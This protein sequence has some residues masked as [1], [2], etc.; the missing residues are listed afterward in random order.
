M[1]FRYALHSL[2]K[3]PGF[4]AIAVLALGVGLGLSTTMFAILDSIRHP[5]SVYRDVQSLYVVSAWTNSRTS[6]FPLAELY[7]IVREQTRSF[8]AVT[9]VAGRQMTLRTPDGDEAVPVYLTTPGYFEVTGLEVERG[10][11]FAPGETEA[12]LISAILWRRLFGER[13]DFHDAFITLDSA[14]YPVVGVVPADDRMRSVWLPKPGAGAATENQWFGLPLVRLKPGVTVEQ[15]D[16]ELKLLGKTVSQ[17]LNAGREA[18][19]FNIFPLVWQ[20]DEIKDVHKAMLGASLGVLLIA[21]VNLAH[22]MLARGMARRRELALRMALGA[23]RSVVIRQMLAECGI[24]TL[25]GIAIGVVIAVWGGAVLANRMPPEVE[26]I[27]MVRPHLSW[28]VFASGAAAATVSALLFGLLPAV[29]IAASVDIADPLKDDSGTT[30]GRVRQRYNGLVIAEVAL[31]LVLLMGAGLLLRT[32]RQL[33]RY[34]LGIDTRTLYRGEIF[35]REDPRARRDTANRAQRR[36]DLLATAR[37]APGI[38]EVSLY[39]SLRLPGNGMTAELTSGD[40]ARFIRA[41]TVLVVEPNYLSLLGLPVLRG[42][43]FEPGDAAG[44]GVAILDTKAA[45]MLYPNQDPIGHMVRLGGPT[46][47]QG[48]AVP[49]VGM[50]R[51]ERPLESKDRFGAAAEPQVYVARADTSPKGAMLI[52]LRTPNARFPAQLQARALALGGRLARFYVRPYEEQRTAELISRRF[53]ANVFVTMGAVALALAAL[54]LYGVLAYAVSRRMREFAVR[55]ALGAEPQVL[56]RMV[57]HDG[58]VM[59]L[60]G[61]GVGAFGALAASRMLD[62]VLVSVLPSDV[63]S[64]CLSEAVL[65]TVGFLAALAPARRAARANPLDILRAT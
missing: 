65:L 18:F 64:L 32:V 56:R 17:R 35:F 16:A 60:A 44:T 9:Q 47:A 57:L 34:D 40:S 1:T 61:T 48:T 41:R 58:A 39:S 31:A 55:M 5:Y 13:K 36:A 2:A 4:V 12:V 8:A 15:A 21:C 43:N 38:Q 62:Q 14:S 42:R 25:G 20:R 37:G 22:L 51:S 52:R 29:R 50:V 23:T 33:E 19:G 54:G 26:W 59:I 53:L 27:G 49:I 28:R 3:S 11:M 30:T 6:A 45:Q 24:M 63:V 7:R 10:R 46:T